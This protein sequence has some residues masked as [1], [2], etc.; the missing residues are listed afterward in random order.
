MAAVKPVCSII[1]QTGTRTTNSPGKLERLC[2]EQQNQ[3]FGQYLCTKSTSI[4]TLACIQFRTIRLVNK[5]QAEQIRRAPPK[6]A[7][8]S[9]QINN[10]MHGSDISWCPEPGQTY[11]TFG[12]H[13]CGT[14]DYGRMEAECYLRANGEKKRQWA[15]GQVGLF[16]RGSF[17]YYHIN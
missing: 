11:D 7:H 8:S 6:K 15:D 12:R 4:S 14:K 17:V 10:K 3:C 2:V 13:S 5:T 16:M 9:Q 1:L